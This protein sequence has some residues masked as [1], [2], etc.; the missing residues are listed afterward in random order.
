MGQAPAAAL[1]EAALAAGPSPLPPAAGLPLVGRAAEWQT[2]RA[3]YQGS[4]S[5]GRLVVLEGEAAS[6]W[7]R[8][9]Q[10]FA[11]GATEGPAAGRF[12]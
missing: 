9:A 7:M 10:A 12:A 1:T 5:D 6:D 4:A 2:L 3:S 8:V 11:G